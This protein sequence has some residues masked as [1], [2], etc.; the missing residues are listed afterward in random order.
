[1]EKCTFCLQRIAEARVAA[2]IANRPVGGNEVRTACQAACPT[3]AFTFGNM[4]Q[5]DADVLTRKR[6]PL[7]YALLGD[8]NTHPRVTYE[9]RIDNPNPA[10]GTGRGA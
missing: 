3:Q 10:A 6:S 2:D 8:Q 1:M 4:A 9:A 5:P 7:S